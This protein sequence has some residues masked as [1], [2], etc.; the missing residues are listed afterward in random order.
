[1]KQDMNAAYELCER[2]AR[3]QAKNFYYAFR[4]LPAERRRAIYAAYAYCRLCDD[5]A[6]GDMP[7]A[8]KARRF[9]ALRS[10]LDSALSGGSDDPVLAA[11]AHSAARFGFSRENLLEVIEGVEMDLVKTRF[12]DFAELREYCYKVASVVGLISIEIFG[13]TDPAAR[14]HAVDLGLAMQLTNIMRDVREDADRG[15][16]YIPRDEMDSVGYSE[17]DLMAGVLDDRFRSLMGIQARRARQYFDSGERLLPLLSPRSRACPAV[18]H[19]LY[20]TIL[21]RIEKSGFDVFEQRIGLSA[22]EKVA[23]MARLWTMSL[24]R[25]LAAGGR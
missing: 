5:I 7:A 4:T 22:P 20:S 24:V 12:A 14:R 6:D 21:G 11:V 13:Y 23:L 18:L 8:E 10:Q 9:D 17:A 2:V 25:S 16:I 15:R 1:M 19:G 3:T